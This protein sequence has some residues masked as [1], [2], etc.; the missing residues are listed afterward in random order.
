MRRGS[1]FLNVCRTANFAISGYSLTCPRR[2]E[3]VMRPRLNALLLI[4]FLI[5]WGGHIN[6]SH[7]QGKFLQPDYLVQNLQFSPTHRTELDLWVRTEIPYYSF[8]TGNWILGKKIGILKKGTRISILQK[9][10]VGLTQ[11]WLEVQY[12]LPNGTLSGGPGHWIWAGQKDSWEN[13]T[14]LPEST[15]GKKGPSSPAFSFMGN[16]W[17]QGDTIPGSAVIQ[18]ADVPNIPTQAMGE[19]EII[20]QELDSRTFLVFCYLGIYA[21]LFSGMLIGSLW[22]WLSSKSSETPSST[23]GSQWKPALRLMIGSVI[24]FSF[25]IGPIMGIGELGFSFSSAILAFHFGLVH[26]DPT[27]L[28]HSL[29][30]KYLPK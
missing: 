18:N 15:S 11:L 29:K 7:V 3:M 17:A 24:S 6:F 10:V 13:I 4:L 21:C 27:D 28:V 2:K 20:R 8:R 25:F 9:E 30:Q 1:K 26:S 23:N 16:A 14:P 5:F 12:E 22:E 19:N